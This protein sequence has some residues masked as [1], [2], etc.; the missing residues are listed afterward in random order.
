MPDLQSYCIILK[1][2]LECKA[3]VCLLLN[4]LLLIC[5]ESFGSVESV[6]A[7]SDVY[8]PIGGEVIAVNEV[9]TKSCCHLSP[10]MHL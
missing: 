3:F 9:S 2:R 8:M 5:R 1:E 6:K 4:P 7:A 10:A